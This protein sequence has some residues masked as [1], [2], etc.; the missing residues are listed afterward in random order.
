MMMIFVGVKIVKNKRSREIAAFFCS[1]DDEHTS[2][3]TLLENL[4]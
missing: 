3:V 1:R 2:A 4:G